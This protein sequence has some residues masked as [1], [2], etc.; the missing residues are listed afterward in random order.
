MA[1]PEG[2][3]PPLPPNAALRWHVVR[4]R[5]DDVAPGTI[6]ELGTGQGAV[7]ARLA[8]R[9]TYTGVE[10]DET[11]RATAA[12][13]VGAKGQIVADI[14]ALA[15]DETVD[16]LCAFEVLEHIDD[17]VGVLASWVKHV[18]PGG[19]VLVSVPAE[20]DRFG[21]FD[22]LVGHLRRYT[23]DDLV[24]LFEN[25]G[26]EAVSV[27]HYGFPL[28][29]VLETGRNFI[30]R[31]RLARKATPQDAATRTAGSGRNLQPPAWA[32]SV[33]WWATVPFRLAQERFPTRGTGLVGLA[34][35]PESPA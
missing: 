16:M 24:K 14:D 11:S 20:P 23:H 34:R 7:A 15:A 17:D 2:N 31:R 35:R 9:A 19:H 33:I 30:G 1:S 4:K 5:V 8:D 25:A 26:L 13:R 21:P 32:G 22:E 12:G 3:F 18:R 10:P 27:E 28:G 29:N 6:L